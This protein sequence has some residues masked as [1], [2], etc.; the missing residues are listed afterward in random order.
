MTHLAK[1]T[2]FEQLQPRFIYYAKDLIQF[3]F[4]LQIFVN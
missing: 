1:L 3:Q 4:M 2:E